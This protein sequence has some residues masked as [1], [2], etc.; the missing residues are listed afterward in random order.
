M[1]NRPTQPAAREDAVEGPK[2]EERGSTRGRESKTSRE[3][4][5]AEREHNLD[6]ALEETFPASDPVSIYLRPN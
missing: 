6:E 1:A 3:R 5:V 4:K 2:T